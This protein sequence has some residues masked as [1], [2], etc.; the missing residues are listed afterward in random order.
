MSNRSLRTAFALEVENKAS[1]DCKL[2]I[3][4]ATSGGF[5]VT[6][7][8]SPRVMK[9]EKKTI[10]FRLSNGGLFQLECEGSSRDLLDLTGPEFTVRDK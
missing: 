5:S 1:K 6:Y 4:L 7:D 3:E 2:S 9:G 10:N 8:S